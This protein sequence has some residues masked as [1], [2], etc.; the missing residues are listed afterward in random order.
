MSRVSLRQFVHTLRD[1][2]G[3]S[4]GAPSDADLLAR[5]AAAGDRPAFEL[6]VLR[7]GPMVFQVCR[8]LLRHTQDAEDAFQATFLT[9][10]RKATSVRRP[11][12]LAGWLHCTAH[13]VALRLITRRPTVTPL[14][15]DRP[16][17][18]PPAPE[19]GELLALVEQEV[20]QLPE[21]YRL[22]VVLC[23]LD[24]RGT[25][26]AATV[27]GCAPGTVFSRLA[28]ARERLRERL[29]RRGVSRP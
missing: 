2:L 25:Q 4:S 17:P 26:E 19:D 15:A 20:R 18:P 12:A 13:R 8:R 23:Y 28:W 3:P 21:K 7:H 29:A 14:D 16:G 11:E 27:L 10:A 22:V 24:G 5:F 9:L 6:L 1:T